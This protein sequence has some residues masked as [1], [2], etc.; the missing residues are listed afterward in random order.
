MARMGRRR[1]QEG[2]SGR[3]NWGNEES[4]LTMS[5][6][7]LGLGLSSAGWIYE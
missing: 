1:V 6:Y 5:S 4:S 7:D 2:L 3:D